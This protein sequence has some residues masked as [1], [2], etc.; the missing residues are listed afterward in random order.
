MSTVY[1]QAMLDAL[2]EAIATGATSIQYADK[3][4]EYRSMT[5][6]LRA[7]DF[8][9]RKVNPPIEGANRIY[10]TLSKGLTPGRGGSCN[11]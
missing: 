8:I 6:M 3:K 5:E 9:S 7:R 11:E 10:P 4:I 1:T 2:D